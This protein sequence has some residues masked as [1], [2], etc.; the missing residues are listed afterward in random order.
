MTDPDRT[1]RT[2][3]GHRL[4]TQADA[5]DQAMYNAVTN[6]PTPTIDVAATWL[7]K[8]ANYSMLSITIAGVLATIGGSRGRHAALRGLTAVGTTSLVA[9]LVAKSLF[10][11]DRPTRT[12]NPGRSARMPDSSSFPSGHAASAFAFA[13]G[14][15]GDFPHLALPLYTLAT[16]VG[17][18]RVHMGVHYPSDAMGGAVL[19][20][21]VGTVVRET[22]L[23][24]ASR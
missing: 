6:T 17:Y 1:A 8:A 19:G 4:T 16:A 11:R 7:T 24:V 20:L 22:T 2:D 5:L 12:T 14:V 13:A 21:A 10:P 15:T 18:S 23:R 9:N 3:V